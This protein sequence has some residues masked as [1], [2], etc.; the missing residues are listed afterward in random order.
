ML[1]SSLFLGKFEPEPVA[2]PYAGDGEHAFVDQLLN[3]QT[4]IL[5]AAGRLVL[6]SSDFMICHIIPPSVF[7]Y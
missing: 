7:D 1:P 3:I 2:V 5:R 6:L 4:H